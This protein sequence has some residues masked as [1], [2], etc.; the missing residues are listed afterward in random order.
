MARVVVRR[1]L[2]LALA[3]AAGVLLLRSGAVQTHVLNVAAAFEQ[4]RPET[5]FLV[6][7]LTAIAALLSGGIWSRLLSCMGHNVPVSAGMGAFASAGLAGYLVNTAGSAVGGAVVL[8]RHGIGP[9]RAVIVTLIANALGLC[10]LLLW[11]P[12]GLLLLSQAGVS[13]G[14]PLLGR[15]GPAAVAWVCVGLALAMVVSLKALVSAD[16]AGHIAAKVLRKRTHGMASEPAE[17]ACPLRTGYL[18]SLVVWSAVTWFVGTLALYVML[19]GLCPTIDLSLPDVVGASVLA[20][21]FSS[22]AFFVPSGVGVR[23]GVLIAVLAHTTGAPVASCTAAALAIRALDPLSKVGLLLIV[24]SGLFEWLSEHH[25]QGVTFLGTML[26]PDGHRAITVS[27][28][29]TSR[30]LSNPLLE[31]IP[32]ERD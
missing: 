26:R 4:L 5:V 14:L 28:A 17:T 10:G 30:R 3:S 31:A 19:G 23:D 7:L 18:L 22:V 29:R 24:A 13:D 8:G 12:V 16:R 9:K 32:I 6:L 11:A 1:V 2:V 25:R 15:Y 20:A 27:L 21:T